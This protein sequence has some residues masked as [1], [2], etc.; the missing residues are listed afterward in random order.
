MMTNK[1]SMCVP[2]LVF[3]KQWPFQVD[4]IRTNFFK[5]WGNQL[6]G[7]GCDNRRRRRNI[8]YLILIILSLPTLLYKSCIQGKPITYDGC[9]YFAT[10]DSIACFFND[11]LLMHELL[12]MHMKPWDGFYCLRVFLGAWLI[13]PRHDPKNEN[14]ELRRFQ[15]S[16]WMHWSTQ[17]I[18]I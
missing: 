12:V 16:K 11:K 4:H 2:L 14:Q 3:A 15:S 10:I 9:V 1:F 5:L 6:G 17:K 13:K 7:E 18:W 8:Q